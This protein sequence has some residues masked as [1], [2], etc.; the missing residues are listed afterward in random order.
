MAKKEGYKRISQDER[1][2]YYED[3]HFIWKLEGSV[4]TMQR[5]KPFE[6]CRDEKEV[7]KELKSWHPKNVEPRI[8]RLKQRGVKII[9]FWVMEPYVEVIKAYHEVHGRRFEVVR[10][11]ERAYFCRLYL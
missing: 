10:E 4:L 11:E 5:T 9:E 3:E 7:E 2:E 6:T 1:A 8:E